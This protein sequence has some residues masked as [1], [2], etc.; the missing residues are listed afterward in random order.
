M[1]YKI[2]VKNCKFAPVS[3]DTDSTYTLGTA[4]LLPGLQEW[5]L[6]PLTASGELYGDGALVSSTSKITGA[7]LRISLAKLTQ[8]QRAGLFGHTI[9][10]KGILRVKTTDTAPKVA[11]YGEVEHDDGGKEQ[12]WLLAGYANTTGLTAKQIESAITYGNDTIELKFFRRN[13]DK[14]V[15]ALGDT[16]NSTFTDSIS[17]A[18][19][20]DPDPT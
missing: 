2:N 16:D 13:K 11:V 10:S 3:V 14:Q 4:V 9:D 8:A 19:A 5:D 20:S 15:Y 7:T 1:G 18:F 12:M 6:Q 17:E